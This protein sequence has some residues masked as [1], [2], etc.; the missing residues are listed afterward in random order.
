MKCLVCSASW[1]DDQGPSCPSCHH[2][3]AAPHARELPA[4]NAAR[5]AF[6]DRTTAYA[7]DRR[8]SRWDRLRPWAGFVLGFVFFVLWLRACSTGGFRL[9]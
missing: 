8:V 6:R 4:L 9:W 1:P 7:P 3:H 5:A 2:D